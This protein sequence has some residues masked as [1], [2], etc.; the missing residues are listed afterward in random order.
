MSVTAERHPEGEH[1]PK[2]TIQTIQKKK[3]QGERITCLTAYDYAGAR[4]VDEAGIDMVLV[5]DS[6]GMVMLGYENTLPVTMQEMLHHTRAVRR[7]VKRAFL[8]A[9][10]PFASYHVS[11]RETL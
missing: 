7:G 8:V 4:L 1:R 3:E 6:L 5:G 2:I 10:M 9:D 11:Q